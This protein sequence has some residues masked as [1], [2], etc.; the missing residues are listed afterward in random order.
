MKTD[1]CHSGTGAALIY[2]AEYQPK[3]TYYSTQQALKDGKKTAS[4][5]HGIKV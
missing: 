1:P 4:M 2:D 5:F 3:S